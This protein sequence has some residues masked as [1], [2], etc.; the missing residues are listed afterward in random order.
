MCDYKNINKNAWNLKTDLHV[1]SRFYDNEFFLQGNSS[2][3]GI[4]LDLLG[5]IR[6]KSV[7]HL[8]CHF[9][10]DSISLSRLGAKVTGIDLSDKAINYARKMADELKVDTK[11]ICSDIYELPA[12]LEEKFDIVFTSYGVIG[13][14]PDL[15]KWAN[16]I[17]HYLKPDGRFIIAEFHPMVWM[18]DDN[19]SE[20]TYDYFN[21]GE[22]VEQIGG[23]YA[24]R[25]AEIQ[26][27]TITWNHSLSEVVNNLIQSGIRISRFEEFDYSPYNC[28]NPTIQ[29]EKDKYRIKHLDSKIP[30]VFAIEGIRN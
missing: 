29:I 18:F 13:W 8:Q 3:K 6:N 11:F 19:F 15:E 4:E 21:V 2:L 23:S 27:T 25:N 1:N 7:L 5:D 14:L 9:G 16:I 10:Q 24:D 22:I 26:Y 28:F 30:M 12:V 20:I 17:S